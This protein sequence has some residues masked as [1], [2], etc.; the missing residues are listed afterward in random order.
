MEK[1]LGIMDVSKAR[2]IPPGGHRYQL[3][4]DVILPVQCSDIGIITI[5]DSDMTARL[6]GLVV[7]IIIPRHPIQ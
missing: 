1:Q 3:T 4:S 7:T 6:G 5:L 2:L